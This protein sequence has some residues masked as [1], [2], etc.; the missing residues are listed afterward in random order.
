MK[1]LTAEWRKLAIINYEINPEILLPYLPKGTELDLYQGKCLVSLVGFMFLNTKL[2][3]ISVPFHKNFE[4]VNLRFYVKKLENEVWKRGVVF[5]K[6]IVPKKTLSLVANKFY[7]ENYYTL[8]MSHLIIES[9][10]EIS[11]F[12]SWQT[13]KLNT[14]ALKV[15]NIQEEMIGDSDFE[16]ITEHYFGFTKNEI[17]TSEYEVKHP[18]WNFYEVKNYEITVDFKENYGTDFTVLNNSKPISVMLAEG[19]EI[20]VHT[21]RNLEFII[22]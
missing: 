5:I 10:N 1:F 7:N 16:F 4:E 21:K 13:S 6:E 8:P 9:D 20:E 19:S 12:Y 14:M 3:G 18:K 17:Q 22:N 15:A 2:L 11:V